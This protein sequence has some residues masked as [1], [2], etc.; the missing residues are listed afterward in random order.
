MKLILGVW[1]VM[2]YMDLACL[3]RL[4]NIDEKR[5]C[6]RSSYALSLLSVRRK[7]NYA[8]E[9]LFCIH[10]SQAQPAEITARTNTSLLQGDTAL[11]FKQM[12]KE[13]QQ[14]RFDGAFHSMYLIT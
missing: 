11:L 9:K 5:R 4:F 2:W 10:L 3:R 14:Y 13:E 8:A 12:A 6:K 7:R 1:A